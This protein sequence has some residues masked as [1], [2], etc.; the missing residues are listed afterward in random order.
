MPK[1]RKPWY[2]LR[3]FALLL[4]AAVAAL[5]A[6]EVYL[7]VTAKPGPPV[8][9]YKPAAELVRKYEPAGA[10]DEPNAWP[11]LLEAIGDLAD[12]QAGG[13]TARQIDFTALYDQ[14]SNAEYALTWEDRKT[15]ARAGLAACREQGL[16]DALARLAASHRAER[17]LPD[18]GPM[19]AILLP[20][21]GASRQLA[22]MCAGRMAA[23]RADGDDAEFVAAFEQLLGIGRVISHQFTLIDHLVGIAIDA[24]AMNCVLETLTER[25]LSASTLRAL[26]A[27]MDRQLP[28]PP[29]SLPLSGE[30]L[31]TLDIIQWTHTDDGRGSGRYIPA[32]AQQLLGNS[33]IGSGAAASGGLLGWL[34]EWHLLNLA[35]VA[36]P[37]KAATTAKAEEFYTELLSV[38]DK[39]AAERRAMG[40]DGDAEVEKI[41]E[42]YVVVREVI[43][44]TSKALAA[45]DQLESEIAAMRLMLAIE[46]YAAER[47]GYPATLED[48]VPAYVPALPQDPI[49]LK[50]FGYRVLKPGE[51]TLKRADGRERPYLMYSL[52]A[53]GVDDGGHFKIKNN[54]SVLRNPKLKEDFVY[55]MPAY[56]ASADPQGR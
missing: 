6:R 38:C 28:L 9:Y 36:F 51:D 3:N 4:N 45:R 40:Y 37:S 26:A 56:R 43:P 34:E 32:A 49:S 53:D 7:A 13:Q 46:L 30:R 17:P 25:P 48:L 55:N 18:Q 14:P 21:L 5:I 41:P 20:E 27:A 23:A 12:A 29:M 54:Y 39:P 1:P 42:R 24:L 15:L 19:I 22:R 16:F 44:A 52:G 11:A 33:G 8:N 10:A 50:G 31:S 47:G 2:R 35:S